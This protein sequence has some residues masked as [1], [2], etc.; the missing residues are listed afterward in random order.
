MYIGSTGPKGLH[1]LVYEI[2]DNAIDEA[3][4]GYCTEIEVEILSGDI[5]RVPITDV[6]FL[7]VYTQRRKYLIFII[8]IL[9]IH[10]GYFLGVLDLDLVVI[11]QKIT[12]SSLGFL[13]YHL[14]SLIHH[15]GIL[16]KRRKNMV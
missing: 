15:S 16:L 8:I 3:L 6:V 1:H 5:I 9:L 14:I 13:S 2:V 11:F 12:P 7:Q 10:H 4:A